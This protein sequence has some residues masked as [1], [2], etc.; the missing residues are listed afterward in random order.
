MTLKHRSVGAGLGVALV[1]GLIA[2]EVTADEETLPG[3]VII[4]TDAIAD[5]ETVNLTDFEEH[6]RG[7]GFAVY[8]V[9]EDDFGGGLGDT[10]AENIRDWLQSNHET[11]DIEYV[12]LVGNP[13]VNNVEPNDSIP[14]K[15]LIGNTPSDMYYGD[16]TG[17]WDLDEDGLY[18]VWP[19]DFGP[20]GVNL[21]PDVFVGRIPCYMSEPN[22]ADDL[23][24]ILTKIIAYQSEDDPN[25][26][27]WRKKVLLAIKQVSDQS[28][29]L[30]EEIRDDLLVPEGWSYLRVY[31][32]EFGLDPAPNTPCNPNTVT[33]AWVDERPGLV[34]WLAHGT[35]TWSEAMTAEKIPELDDD[36]PA[37]TLQQSCSTGCSWI[38][39]NLAYALLKHGAIAT[40]APVYPGG[41]PKSR[42][43]WRGYEYAARLCIAGVSCGQA[44]FEWRQFDEPTTE[45][46]WFGHI[47]FN[48]YGDPETYLLPPPVGD[49]N[50][51]VQNATQDEWYAAIQP[52]ID[53]AN[54]GD[55][56]VLSPGTYTGQ[57]NRDIDYGGKA[58]VVR[59]SNPYNPDVVAATIIDPNAEG[60]GFSF[61]N[62]E[63]LDSYINGVTITNGYAD[64]G[65]GIFC[66]HA[67]PT[68]RNCVI[69]GNE[70]STYG[71][72]ISCWSISSP[73]IEDC[74]IEEN[75]APEAGGILCGGWSSPTMN[76]CTIT[77][78]EAT[79]T[80]ATGRCGGIACYGCS[81]PN[82]SQCIISGN[83]AGLH[84]G[85][86][87]C[88]ISCA[89]SITSCMITDNT[90]GSDGGGVYIHDQSLPTIINC[91][92]AG[93][94]AGGYG[95]GICCEDSSPPTIVNTIFWSDTVVDPNNG[96]EI[97]VFG[98]SEL[99]LL[100][101]DVA[102][103]ATDAYVEEPNSTLIWDPEYNLTAN[104]RFVDAQAGDYHLKSNS[105]CIGAGDPSRD[106]SWQKDVDFEQ[107]S[108]DG[109]DIGADES[110]GQCG[111]GAGLPLLALALGGMRMVWR[112]RKP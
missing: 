50:T 106:Y 93:N 35:A 4:T 53:D 80:G 37:F 71:G 78:N 31:D 94:S 12:L 57:D 26:L 75:S 105:P 9:T 47:I 102:G 101:C 7:R 27:A 30:G 18:G 19:N 87:G 95:G 59:G 11:L 44:F 10:A 25:A 74:A 63:G 61:T 91:T 36:Y 67:K 20:G 21:A 5:N 24:G 2:S 34:V 42:R 51:P 22:W 66:G 13:D 89:P 64:M 16:L 83:T 100:Y 39:D 58:I 99:E 43:H 110:M 97:A 77:D 14:M 88:T 23:A 45:S 81:D 103:G 112:R 96:P 62:R 76:R 29:M 98:S 28:Y 111:S 107:R 49:P 65:G 1:F 41:G 86:I 3:Y 73:T 55:V 68:I 17:N 6:K 46:E 70:A 84:A 40:V 69:T 79:G 54:D 104:P 56:I 48:L 72:G 108:L 85:G 15:H 52:A 109:V 60:R 32:E 33:A 92:V 38:P 82:I 8:R 90:A